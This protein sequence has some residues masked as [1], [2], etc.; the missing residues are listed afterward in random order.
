MT[1]IPSHSTYCKIPEL[2]QFIS[3]LTLQ[4]SLPVAFLCSNEHTF[5]P[6]IQPM[7]LFMYAASFPPLNFL[8]GKKLHIHKTSF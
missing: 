3:P 2:C 7:P 4:Q 1:L 5:F 8:Q 6:D